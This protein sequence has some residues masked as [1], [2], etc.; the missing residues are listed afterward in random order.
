[1]ARMAIP[2]KNQRF[3]GTLRATRAVAAGVPCSCMVGGHHFLSWV[4]Y[5]LLVS[6]VSTRRDYLRNIAVTPT[7]IQSS[8]RP[9]FVSEAEPAA[10]S[11]FLVVAGLQTG[12]SPHRQASEKRKARL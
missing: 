6:K 1:M 3:Y 8:R 2:M 12:K 10:M 9:I 4:N 5:D 11:F 7:K